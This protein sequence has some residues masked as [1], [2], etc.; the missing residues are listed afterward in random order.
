MGGVTGYI[1][2]RRNDIRNAF[3]GAYKRLSYNRYAVTYRVTNNADDKVR[4]ERVMLIVLVKPGPY[5]DSVRK[6]LVAAFQRQFNTTIEPIV[7]CVT[8][9]NGNSQDE[10]MR[11]KKFHIKHGGDKIGK[12]VGF[13]YSPSMNDIKEILGLKDLSVLEITPLD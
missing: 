13:Q 2:H 8:H 10:I 5:N 12:I 7:E 11:L 4:D 1:V 9:I 6:E 3:I